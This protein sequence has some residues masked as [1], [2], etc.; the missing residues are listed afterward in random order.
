[1]SKFILQS[2][3]NNKFSKNDIFTKVSDSEGVDEVVNFGD[4][5][6]TLVVETEDKTSIWTNHF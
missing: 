3:V 1:M 5:I 6:S 4:G 2:S